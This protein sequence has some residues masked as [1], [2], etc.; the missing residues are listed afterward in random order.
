MAD[1]P[2]DIMKL[3]DSLAQEIRRVDGGHNCG[4]GELAERLMP[5]ISAAI[6]AER[7]RCA[8]DGRRIRSSLEHMCAIIEHCSVTEG[9]CCC[10]DSMDNHSMFSGHGPVDHGSYVA[11]QALIEARAILETTP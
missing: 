2:E 10:G 4:A 9:V 5:F 1:I 7:Q 8:D 3:A 11:E 6:L